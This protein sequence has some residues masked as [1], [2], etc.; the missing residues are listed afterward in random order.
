MTEVEPISYESTTSPEVIVPKYDAILV[1]GYWM[2]EHP[3]G[4]AL[5]SRLAARAAALAYDEG[6]GARKIVV[7]LG[8][9][10]GPEYP[11]T[12]LLI[13]GELQEKYGVP[14]ES[15]IFRE[16]SYSTGGEVKTFVELAEE[17]G[18]NNLLDIAFS[19][20]YLTI[21][22]I[23]REYDIQ[24]RVTFRSVEDIL[25][26][27][28][29]HR[30]NRTYK[31]RRLLNPGVPIHE[32]LYEESDEERT[33]SFE[34]NNTAGLIENLSG[35]RYG[36]AYRFYEKAKWARMHIPGFSYDS[37]ERKNKA[38]RL[39]LGKGKE[40]PVPIDVYKL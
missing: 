11:S 30:I 18:W 20:H 14:P 39:K 40:F 2:S 23:Y 3:S 5:R 35:S 9:Q 21:P 29:I 16:E 17:N 10:W 27:K 28:D 13:A 7:D 36:I 4:L 34:H 37:L 26:E 32:R 31:K 33:V 6:R 8:F 15:I 12:G 1:H 38:K 19:N 25:R 22:D 24:A